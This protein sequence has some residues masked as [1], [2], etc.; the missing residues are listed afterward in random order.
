VASAP[1]FNIFVL[2]LEP[3]F[4][5]CFLL[6]SLERPLGLILGFNYL[7]ADQN[8]ELTAPYRFNLFSTSS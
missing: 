4:N 1:L 2:K 8:N 7:A 6:F 5:L 3:S